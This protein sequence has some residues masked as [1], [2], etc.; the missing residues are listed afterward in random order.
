[1]VLAWALAMTQPE[2]RAV[3]Y[4]LTLGLATDLAR[5]ALRLGALADGYT[6]AAGGPLTGWYR[7]AGHVSQA[8]FVAWPAGIAA[9]AMYVYRRRSPRPVIVAWALMVGA[10]VLAHPTYRG[11]ALSRVYFGAQLV[12]QLVAVGCAAVWVRAS[13]RV[14]RAADVHHVA[15]AFV[16]V[17]EFGLV[18]AGPW[19]RDLF[20]RWSLAAIGYATLYGALIVLQA[21]SL[22]ARLAS[23]QGG[24]R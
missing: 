11:P 5:R 16:I 22:C 2:H 4:L 17:T 14:R 1:M 20:G 13:V 10:L 19:T 18:L 21:G 23:L 8:L 3:A 6:L 24:S 12:A 15:L 9:C 7:V